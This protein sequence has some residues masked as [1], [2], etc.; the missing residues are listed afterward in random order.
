MCLSHTYVHTYICMTYITNCQ[1]IILLPRMLHVIAAQSL[2]DNLPQ[3]DFEP[4]SLAVVYLQ[5]K[6]SI[7]KPWPDFVVLGSVSNLSI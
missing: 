2:F 7:L 3:Y 4:L 1:Q 5:H 6:S